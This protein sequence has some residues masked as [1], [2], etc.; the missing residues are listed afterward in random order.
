VIT[1]AQLVRVMPLARKRID[2]WLAPINEAMIEY[3]IDTP[4]RIAA[5]LAQI[6]HESG[7]LRYVRENASGEAYE[8]RLDLGNTQPGDGPRFRGRGLI[9]I[10]GRHNYRQC[11]IALFGIAELLLDAPETLEQP[12]HAARSA[13]W[14]WWS[15]G[16]NILADC[17]DSFATIT[18]RI[19]GGLNG[20][21]DRLA[22]YARAQEI[23]S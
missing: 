14:Y 13:A 7:S 3:G 8:G 21:A 2:L 10:T 12:M 23:F 18:R 6:A 22:Y 9:Q 20:Q 16:L 19:N 15:R 11:S 1:E 5:F 4:R 17:P